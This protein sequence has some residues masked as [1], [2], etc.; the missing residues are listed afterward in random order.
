MD[1]SRNLMAA[2]VGRPNVGKST[3]L[4]AFIGEKIAIVSDKPQT[5]R[6]RIM[7][8]LTAGPDQIVFIDTPGFHKARTKLSNYMLEQIGNSVSD[9]DIAVFVTDADKDILQNE[10]ELLENLKKSKIPALLV[11]NK[12]DVLERKELML[13]KIDAFSKLADFDEI[14]PVSAKYGDGVSI[15]LES[16]KK[17]AVAGPHLFPDDSITD[18][19]ERV[20]ASEIIR[21]KMLLNLEKEI[22]HGI[23]V[24]IEKMS[25]RED[26]NIID[27]DAVIFCE[28]SSH[29]GIVIGKHGDMLKKIASSARCDMENFFAAKINLQCWVKVKED[30]RNREGLI[31]NFGYK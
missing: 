19:T 23:A 4:N 17:Y 9:V 28:K 8:V 14:I 1:N 25:E 3:L 24:T 27:I 26:K 30:W 22:P 13:S 20:I 5:T 21:E 10:I 29:K 7:G 6:T 11:V 2:I 18:Q 12:I 16:I 15:L 31:K